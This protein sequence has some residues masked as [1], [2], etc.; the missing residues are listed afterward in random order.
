MAIVPLGSSLLAIFFSFIIFFSNHLSPLLSERLT[1]SSSSQEVSHRKAKKHVRIKVLHYILP[2]WGI[3]R[4]GDFSCDKHVKCDWI[5]GEQLVNL[6]NHMQHSL[7]SHHNIPLVSVALYNIHTLWEKYRNLKPQICQLSTNISMY[8]TEESVAR[9]SWYFDNANVN[10]DGYSSTH[11]NAQVQRVYAEAFLNASDFLPR[12][13]FS[14]LIKAG[15]YIAS[16]CHRRDGANSNRDGVVTNIRNLGF[17]V[18]GLGRCLRTNSI[19]E[20]INLQ[21]FFRNT[22]YNLHLKREVL[23]YYAFY[24]AFENSIEPGYV[25]EKPF[26]ALLAGMRYSSPITFAVS[27]FTTDVL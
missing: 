22:Q 5:V 8:E 6:R 18:D 27:K 10:F 26:D 2:H 13:N 20:G 7:E 25:T 11:P 4:T 9:F 23:N 3:S 12:R 1:E 14:S 24:L 17:R 16:D 19:P 15:A 21:K